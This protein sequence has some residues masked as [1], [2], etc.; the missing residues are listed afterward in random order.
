MLEHD[1]QRDP[2]CTGNSGPSSVAAINDVIQ[3]VFE[4]KIEQDFDLS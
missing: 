2:D 1:C 3:Q 4:A